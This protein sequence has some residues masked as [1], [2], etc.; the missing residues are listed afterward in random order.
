MYLITGGLG[1]V[2]LTIAE[3]LARSVH[4][5]LILTGRGGLPERGEW[6]A[7]LAAHGADDK[8]SRQIRAVEAIEQAGGS[9][10][11]AAADVSSVEQMRALV[12]RVRQRYGRLDGVVHAAGVGAGGVIQIKTDEIAARVLAPKV[13][14]TQAL[15]RALEGVDLDFFVLCSSMTAYFGGGGQA[16]YCAAN[17][18][19][20]AFAVYHSRRAGTFTVSVNW[21][22]WQQVGMA[23]DADLPDNLKRERAEHLKNGISSEEGADA[24]A[25]ILARGTSAQVAISTVP[26]AALFAREAARKAAAERRIVEAAADVSAPTLHPRPEMATGYAAP[27]NEIERA[28][29]GVW[30]P[31]LGIDHVGREDN[32]FDLGGHSLLLVQA[33]AAL[34]EK[35]GRA[36]PVTDLFQF[37]TIQSLA[38]HLGGHRE[39]LA[40]RP[41]E[42]RSDSSNAVAIIGMAGRFPGAPDLDTFWVNLRAGIES[43]HALN[44]DDLRSAGVDEHLLADPR[45]VKVASTLDEVDLFDAGFFGYAPREAEL[46]DP[47]HRLFLE[48]AWEALERAGYDPKQ[49]AGL[50]GVYAGA[51]WSPYLANIFSNTALIESVGALQAGIGNRGDHLPTRVSYKLN[52]RGPSLNVQTACSTSLVAVHQACRSLVDGECD[53]ALAGGV[54]IG[55]SNRTGYLYIE[56]GISSPDGHCRAFDAQAR[57]TVWG[58][59]VGIV[60][61][62]RLADALADGDTIHAVVRG[63][64]IN[65]DGAVKV[66]YTAPSVEG[67][68][69][70]VARAQAVAGVDPATIS[71]IEA[72]GTGTTL[73]DPIEIAALKQA[74]GARSGRYLR[75][76][77]GEDQPGPPRRRRRGGQPHQDRARARTPRAAAEPELRHTEPEDRFRRE[78]VLRERDAP[79]VGEDGGRRSAP[80]WRQFVRHRRHQRP[81][82]ARGS[83]R[84]ARDQRVTCRGRC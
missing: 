59:G 19:L 80:G 23:A 15:A 47:Q 21:D 75:D 25:R 40:P 55:L 6:A 83:A 4:A 12:D 8:A 5:R 32:F 26:L 2:G 53:I 36:L 48:C 16:D 63:T 45:Y 69:A 38:E 62:K 81:C 49:Y 30:G 46:I 11:V 67:Q 79:A 41:V 9:V 34:V 1:G 51:G 39:A 28:I 82:G 64:A 77:H 52:L 73:G 84:T 37:P 68:A 14:G 74:F 43:I 58:D 13:A 20:D 17:A 56:E 60:V 61:L 3:S 35:L 29:A 22:M 27:T 71:Y 50:I 44:D 70:V 7:H 72:H 42:R 18:Y 54:S 33:H 78:P 76:R 57:G 10:E 65:N 31:L 24:F 66:G